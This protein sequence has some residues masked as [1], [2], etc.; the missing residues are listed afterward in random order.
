MLG[1]FPVIC[2]NDRRKSP[3]AGLNWNPWLKKFY[4]YN[5]CNQGYYHEAFRNICENNSQIFPTDHIICTEKV[6]MVIKL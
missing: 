2:F 1:D 3:F 5:V 6:D 4:I